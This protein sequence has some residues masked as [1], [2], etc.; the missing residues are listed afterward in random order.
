[1]VIILLLMS[2]ALL[3]VTRR[4]ME[5]SLSL[6]SGER[7]YYQQVSQAISALNWGGHQRWSSHTGWVCK[8]VDSLAWRA[9]LLQQQP[10]LLRADSGN[11]TVALWQWVEQS[12]TGDLK[13][14]PHGW[15]DFYPLAEDKLCQPD[16]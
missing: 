13:K 12:L 8:T 9:C 16:E 3:N 14:V 11:G 10:S 2:A 1:M 6:L 4:Q 7:V 15:L 5:N